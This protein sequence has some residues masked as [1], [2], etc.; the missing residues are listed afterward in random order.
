METTL[1]HYTAI[2]PEPLP[3]A[4]LGPGAID[5]VF[6]KRLADPLPGP[7]DSTRDEPIAPA[8]GETH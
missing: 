6:A 3:W 1:K 8:A 2:A 5:V 7:S 4:R